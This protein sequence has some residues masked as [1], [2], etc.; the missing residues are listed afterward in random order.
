MNFLYVEVEILKNNGRK[1]QLLLNLKIYKAFAEYRKSNILLV[2][3]YYVVVRL[4]SVTKVQMSN[5][6]YQY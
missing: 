6:W 3:K 1:F 2:V 5:I 4:K